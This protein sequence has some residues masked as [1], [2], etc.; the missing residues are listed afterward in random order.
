MPEDKP[1]L[2]L[3]SKVQRAR[4]MHDAD[5]KPSQ[6]SAVYWIE[7]K[8]QTA[9]TPQPTPRAG[10]WVLDTTVTQVDSQWAQVKQ[11]TE[12]GKLGY[13]SKVS[14]A[15]HDQRDP[16]ARRIVVRTYDSNDQDNVK[17]IGETLSALKLN[18]EW[19]YETE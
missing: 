17:Q 6:V 16:D 15:S 9:D 1:N 8:S 2:D 11:A 5:A 14:T 10:Q 13:K 18:G 12:A 7:A 19:H 4:M 3:I